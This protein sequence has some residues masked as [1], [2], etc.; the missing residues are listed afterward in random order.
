[1]KLVRLAASTQVGGIVAQHYDSLPRWYQNADGDPTWR[2]NLPWLGTFVALPGLAA[3]WA[4]GTDTADP[5]SAV[6][7]LL[8]GVGVLAGLLFQVLASVS[9]RIAD[10]ADRTDPASA[11]DAD[12][13]LVGRLDIARANIAYASLVSI[14]FVVQLGVSAIAKEVP[15]WVVGVSAFLLLHLGVTLVLVLAR[16]N[17]IAQDDRAAALTL[18]ARRRSAR[19]PRRAA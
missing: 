12:I 5:S 18:R 1:M 16:I 15:T 7:G 17:A 9:G 10:L 13:A 14:V 6:G 4:V 11:S 8:A 19:G 2:T 3:W